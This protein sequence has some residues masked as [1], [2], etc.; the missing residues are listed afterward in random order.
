MSKILVIAPDSIH[1]QKF[2]KMVASE[3]DVLLILIRS[4]DAQ[5]RMEYNVEKVL[6]PNK[7]LDFYSLYKAI[8]GFDPD[9]IHVHTI[10]FSCFIVC[11]LNNIILKKRLIASS[12]GSDVLV[13]PNRSFIHKY[14]VKYCV[15]SLDVLTYD[16]F[17]QKYAVSQFAKCKNFV[18]VTFGISSSLYKNSNVKKE[19]I[20]YSSRSH[21]PNYNIGLVLS[22]FASFVKSNPSFRLI[23]SGTEDSMITPK[24]MGEVERLGL[25]NKV[26]IVGILSSELNAEYMSRARIYVSIPT[27]DAKSVS[28]MEAIASNCIVFASDIPANYDMVI[29]GVNGFLSSPEALDFNLYK[30][31]SNDLIN[32]VNLEISKY[33]YDDISRSKFLEIY[34]DDL[35]FQN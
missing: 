17:I 12:W 33:F 1:T 22:S 10:N 11:L 3:H 23:I 27:S 19:D 28:I 35:L 8:K 20:I 2:I 34:N 4:S 5:S 25:S 26:D 32:T 18:E 15:E 30:E 6:I 14:I 29:Q 7:V 31:V 9:F 16:S 24:L 13:V 21:G